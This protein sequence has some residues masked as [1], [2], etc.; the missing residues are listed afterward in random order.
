MALDTIVIEQN[1]RL[2]RSLLWKLQ[3]AFYE[4]RG[5]EAWSQA[6]VPHYITNNPVIAAA[7]A[8]LAAA[9]L[10]DCLSPAAAQPLD[11]NQPIYILELGAGSGRFA[12]YFLKRLLPALQGSSLKN[13]PITYVLSDLPERNV[14]FWQSHPRLAP[15]VAAGQLDFA[16]FDPSEEASIALRVS[17]KRLA[18][19]ELANPL[20]VLANYFFDSIPQD[21]FY[22][23]QGLL[24][25]E[26]AT[27]DCDHPRLGSSDPEIL[28]HLRVRFSPHFTS[29]DYF[30]DPDFN[31]ILGAYLQSLNQAYLQFPTGA[32]EVLRN[33]RQIAA[34]TTN[35]ADGGSRW[36]TRIVINP[37]AFR[38]LSPVGR[39]I[40]IAH[41]LAHE[42]TRRQTTAQTPTWLAEGFADYVG[43]HGQGVPVRSAAYELLQDVRA[44]HVPTALPGPKA[45]AGTADG[46]GQAYE[47][48]WL[49]CRLIAQRYGEKALLSFYEKVGTLGLPRAFEVVLH[50]DEKAFTARWRSYVQG[51][52]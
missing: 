3:R 26:L 22:V 28:P 18:R 23:N 21:A 49:A 32:L 8:R 20:I 29:L 16:R 15:F 52:A 45:F 30:A 7:Y 5:I 13:L 12:F 10:R 1:Q 27:L 47:S 17:G 36:A 4:Q 25:E 46:L 41:E 33:L 9:F 31:V 6:H 48:A 44:G 38:T 51:L 43:Y 11:L 14:A 19:G 40:V 39:R 37:E 42:A 35:S 50:T 24:C 34:V 2:A